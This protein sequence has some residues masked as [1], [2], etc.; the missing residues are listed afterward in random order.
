M[1]HPLDQRSSIWISAPPGA[2]RTA[3]RQAAA[4]RS[5]SGSLPARP[6]MRGRKARLRPSRRRR[7]WRPARGAGSPPAPM[8]RR[9]ASASA[10]L[11]ELEPR[12]A[13]IISTRPA[14]LAPCCGCQRSTMRPGRRIEAAPKAQA[15]RRA[16]TARRRRAGNERDGV[17]D[18][19]RSQ[20][21]HLAGARRGDAFGE[22]AVGDFDA[23]IAGRVIGAFA[24]IGHHRAGADA[25]S[26][27]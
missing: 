19:S 4:S 13:G 2:A 11:P 3:S 20:P 17:E 15:A 16:A 18:A 25:A 26:A 22:R 27:S 6:G 10:A 23:E 14:T 12:P 24:G 8:P 5:Q 21:H 7:R 1:K 9:I